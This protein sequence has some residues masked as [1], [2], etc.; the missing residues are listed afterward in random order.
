[1]KTSKIDMTHGPLLGKLIIFTIP[2]V[3]SGVL[4]LLFNAADVI[5]VGRFAG[6]SSIAAVGSTTSLINLMTNLFVGMS[7]G[8]WY[9][10]VW[11]FKLQDTFIYLNERSKKIKFDELA[12]AQQC[13]QKEVSACMN[14]ESVDKLVISNF[15][16]RYTETSP[17]AVRNV[18]FEAHAGEII[19]FLGP[20]GAGKSTTIK[21]I[22]GIHLP[23]EGKI[24][25]NGYDVAVQPVQAKA[26][27]GFVPDHYALYENLTGRE[28]LNYIADLYNVTE[29]DRNAF[30]DEFLVTLAMK[31][32]IDNK[33]QTYSHGMK[34]KIAIMASIIHNP[35][36][37]ILDEPLT[38]LDPVSIYQVKMCLKKHAEKGNIVFFSS[39]L[40]DIVEK[41]CDRIIIISNHQV[42]DISNVKELANEHID[43]EK[44]YMEKTGL[45][46]GN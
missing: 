21:A 5:V 3:L 6:Q 7:I 41:L 36:L 9:V 13:G 24:E 19:G 12:L 30:L 20:N 32:A 33:I 43:L 18:N 4:Q 44:Y 40:I 16:K 31:D 1:M 23:T 15:G 8:M 28:Y 26:Q 35:K 25:V 39:H 27:L 10:Y 37:W 42:V 34:Q 14:P 22:V 45:A 2:I 17:F 11:L 38:G 46:T 29:E